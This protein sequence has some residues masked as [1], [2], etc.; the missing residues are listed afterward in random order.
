MPNSLHIELPDPL[1]EWVE[2]QVS[3]RGYGTASDY[4][5]DLLRQEQLQEVRDGVDAKLV[6]ALE[7]GPAAEMTLQDWQAVRQEG[8]RTA[9][10]LRRNGK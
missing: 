1:R 10:A 8:Q 5:L 7:S 2:R 6:E 9:E 4:V 3:R